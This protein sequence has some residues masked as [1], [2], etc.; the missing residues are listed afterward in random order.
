MERPQVSGSVEVDAP[1]QAVWDAVTDWEAQDAW[2]LGTT[3]RASAGDGVG[4]RLAAFTGVLGVGFLDSMVVTEW[5]PPRR[6]VVDK[7]GTVVRGLGIIEV[8][9]LGGGRSRL[10]WRDELDLPWGVVGRL[11]FPVVK[12]AF[13]AGVRASLQ[14]L[15][16][17]VEARARG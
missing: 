13:L 3:T 4:Q 1:P 17:Q 15:A 14:R 11:G 5:D 8:E 9:D 12:P 16:R 2:M 7:T 6:V 10:H